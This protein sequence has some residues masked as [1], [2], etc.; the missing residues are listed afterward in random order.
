MASVVLKYT[1]DKSGS[2]PDHRILGEPHTLKPGVNRAI[3]LRYGSFYTH[4]L[5][6]RDAMT[7]QEL[8]PDEQY[9]PIMYYAEPSEISGKEVC[10]G[11][12]VTDGTVSAEVEVD[13]R[14]VGGPYANIVAIMIDLIENLELDNREVL[15]GDLLGKPQFYPPTEHLHNIGDIYG[16]EYVVAAI[17]RVREAVLY[18]DQAIHDEL[19]QQTEQRY[20]QALAEIGRVEEVLDDHRLDTNNPHETTKAQVGLGDVD[21]YSRSHYDARYG[22]AGTGDSQHRNNAQNVAFFDDRNDQRYV[23]KSLNTW[24]TDLQDNPRISIGDTSAPAGFVFRASSTNHEFQYRNTTN[25]PVFRVTHNGHVHANTDFTITSDRRLK[26]DFELITGA[27]EKI[28]RICGY[29]YVKK[30]SPDVR[31]AGVIAQEV[32][33]ILPE[34]VS[35][36]ESGMLSVSYG[37][38][39]PLLIEAIHE[40]DQKIDL[41]KDKRG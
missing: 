22:L 40:L 30:D 10:G 9:V 31:R 20:Q 2:S 11:I 24:F 7:G 12:V 14:V 17:D 21:N 34:A 23:G 15:W 32:E 37:S 38:L 18:R 26:D 33:E 27:L 36:N 25:S 1:H 4:D 6:V 16:F 35:K 13:Y 39:V 8:V 3:I 28:K 41:K 5:V 19:R 29:T